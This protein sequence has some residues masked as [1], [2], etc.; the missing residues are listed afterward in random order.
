V[1]DKLPCPDLT[2]DNVFYKGRD[3][4][5]IP[6]VKFCPRCELDSERLSCRVI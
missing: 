2:H 4:V 1:R 5:T 3:E 6:K